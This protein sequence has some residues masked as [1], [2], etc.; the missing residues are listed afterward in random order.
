MLI[1]GIGDAECVKRVQ[2]GDVDSFE[3]LVRRHQK[4]TFNLV[5]RLLGDYDEAAEVAQEV[6]LSAYKSIQQFRGEANFSTWLYRIAF[7][8]ASTRR[9]SLHLAQQ[10]HV[11]LD[12]TELIGDGDAF[13]DPE[14]TAQ[15]RETQQSVQRAL[16]SLPKDDATIIILRDLQD[17]PYEEVAQ[18]LEIPVG[19]VKSR[20]HRARRALKELLTPHYC[21]NRKAL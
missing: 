9:K 21:P 19:T 14:K 18:M 6:F 10:R 5:Y 11:P 15:D 1:E 17:A 4:A 8:H 2:R 7:N 13:A 16:N 12:G 20:L 3:V